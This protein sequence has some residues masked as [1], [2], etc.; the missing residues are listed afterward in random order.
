MSDQFREQLSALMDGELPRDQVRFLL[1]RVDGD[2]QLAQCW[3]R[4]HLAGSALRRQLALPPLRDDFADVLMQRVGAASPSYG[5]RIMRWAGGGAIA[6]AVAVLALVSTRPGGDLKE[7]APSLVAVPPAATAPAT[8]VSS[9][10]FAPMPLQPAFDFTQ[11]AA[12]VIAMPR[13]HNDPG[14]T[15]PQEMLGPYVLVK[16]PTPAAPEQQPGAQ[17]Q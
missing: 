8:A 11:P 12:A 5:M 2:A 10:N 3:A 6:A 9:R 7:T 1:R 13:Y 15:E 17:R 14:S 4:Y 16:T